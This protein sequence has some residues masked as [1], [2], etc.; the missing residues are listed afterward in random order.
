MSPTTRARVYGLLGHYPENSAQCNP[1]RFPLNGFNQSFAGSGLG[2]TQLETLHGLLYTNARTLCFCDGAILQQLFSTN[3]FK[4]VVQALYGENTFL[5]KLRVR[6]DTDVEAVVKYWAKGG[7]AAAMRPL[8][9]ALTK[10]PGGGPLNVSYLLPPFARVRLYTYAKPAT[11]PTATRQNCFW[12]ALNFF[13]EKPDPQFVSAERA[14]GVL[15]ADYFK[16]E[17][18]AIYGDVIALVD[19]DDKVVHMCIYLADDVVFTKNGI[20]DMQ[21]WVL[22]KVA[23]MMRY[24]VAWAPVQMRVYR[25]RKS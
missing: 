17:Q 19:A 24:Y 23:D 14:R 11:D 18:S 10:V 20:D 3:D 21:P 4:S 6:P 8:L 1:F 22:M 5:M 12:T 2:A 25:S 7:R 15:E 16:T 9:E 13:N